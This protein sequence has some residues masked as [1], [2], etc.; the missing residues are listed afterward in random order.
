MACLL[1]RSSGPTRAGHGLRDLREVERAA[2]EFLRLLEMRKVSGTLD[3]LEFRPG[4]ERAIAAAV[5][6]AQNSV[7]RAPEK[8]RRQLDAVQPALELRI[9]HVGR[10]GKARMRFPVARRS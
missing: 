9:V 6:L 2:G 4:N 1:G 7:G 10:P 5:S 3:G 8:Q